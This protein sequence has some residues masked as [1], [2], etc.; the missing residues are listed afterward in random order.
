MVVG[1]GQLWAVPLTYPK[2]LKELPPA[3]M[4]PP[5][6]PAKYLPAECLIV[7]IKMCRKNYRKNISRYLLSTAVL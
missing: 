6:H 3:D 1:C 7:Y 5:H 2:S 4:V